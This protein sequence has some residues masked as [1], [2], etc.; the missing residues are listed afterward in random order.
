MRGFQ[1][2]YGVQ[3]VIAATTGKVPLERLDRAK[4]TS[5][6]QHKLDET[7]KRRLVLRGR[8]ES[9]TRQKNKK[10]LL[11]NLGLLGSLSLHLLL[12]DGPQGIT[13]SLMR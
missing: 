8:R 7:K 2:L 3:E 5:L 10:D 6:F 11:I 12:P 1:S 4:E 13:M 9:K